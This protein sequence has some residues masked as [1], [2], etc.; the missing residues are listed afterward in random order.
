MAMAYCIQN[1]LLLMVPEE[2]LAELTTDM[3]GGPDPMVVEEAIAKADGEIDAYLG[4]RYTL[5][6]VGVPAQVRSLSV[7]IALYHLYSRRSVMPQVRRQKYEAALAFLKLVAAGQAM[8]EGAG[9][10]TGNS[11]QVEEFSGAT[12]VCDRN[13]LVDW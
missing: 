9:E 11:R 13:G 6:L 1:D 10:P 4:V 2:E 5:P 3:G 8:V 7:E 12:R